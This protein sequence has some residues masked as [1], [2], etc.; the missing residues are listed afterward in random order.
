MSQTVVNFLTDLNVGAGTPNL[1]VQPR[2]FDFE[3]DPDAQALYNSIIADLEAKIASWKA[4]PNDTDLIA[5]SDGINQ[6]NNWSK[7]RL[8]DDMGPDGSLIQT[9]Q[10]LGTSVKLD[11]DGKPLPYCQQNPPLST[12]ATDTEGH[13][14]PPASQPVPWN[15][16]SA[17]ELFL[18][19]PVFSPDFNLPGVSQVSSTMDRYMA[20]ELDKIIRA[21][22][23]AGWDPVDQ[24]VG[25][26]TA[27]RDYPLPNVPTSAITA[28][29]NTALTNLTGANAAIYGIDDLLARAKAVADQAR[30]L[31]NAAA[32]QSSSIQQV[33]MVDY[34][35]RGNELLFNEMSQLREAIDLNQTALSYLNSLQDLMNQK[36]PE[37]FVLQLEQLNDIVIG[38]GSSRDAFDN[39]EQQ[40]YNEAL[41]TIAKFRAT[42]DLA[43]FL[44]DPANSAA[45]SDEV[46]G[47]LPDVFDTATDPITGELVNALSTARTYTIDKILENIDFITSQLTAL[48]T[49]APGSEQG[50]LLALNKIKQ[51]FE[52]IQASDNNPNIL[53]P[54]AKWIEDAQKG[55]EGDHQRHLN[56][57]ITG[58]QSFNDTQREELRRVMFV[59][60]EFYKSATGLLSRLTQLIEKMATSISR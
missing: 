5:I 8:V 9:Y 53:N 13:P 19:K 39:Y 47:D 50:L 54:I 43:T 30:L 15:S 6:L 35:T 33:L 52:V 21:F 34:I 55:E 45:R 3:I 31:G 14:L 24:P 11:A 18:T 26:I 44:T 37:Q 2:I 12:I 41:G 58:S 20:E 40:T 36:D 38:T 46:F 51:D 16:L 60:E 48:T 7:V 22:R 59:F 29:M 17:E 1:V 32:T 57:A 27:T 4:S 49:T 28:G 56:D 23:S 42:G 10:V 25:T